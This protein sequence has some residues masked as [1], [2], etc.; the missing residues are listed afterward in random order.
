MKLYHLVVNNLLYNNQYLFY[1]IENKMKKLFK[2]SIIFTLIWIYLFG[3]SIGLVNAQEMWFEIIPWSTTTNIWDTV[4]KVWVWWSVWDNYKDVAYWEKIDGK[5]WPNTRKWADMSL[6]DQLAS[7]IMTRDTLLDYAVYLVKFIW[8]L[9]LLAWAL[10]IIYYGYVKATEHLKWNGWGK[11][12]MV[13]AW[14][15]VI[16]FAYVIIKM[17]WSMF[18]S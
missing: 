17:V 18:V 4:E 13:V 12:W 2:K 16:S 1:I 14:I 6:W 9:A 3:I 11:L 10:W 5:S 7:G 8:Q 15:L